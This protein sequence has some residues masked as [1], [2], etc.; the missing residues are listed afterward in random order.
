M[1]SVKTMVHHSWPRVKFLTP[2]H[3]C[4]N[5]QMSGV[6][7]SGPRTLG[8]C[9]GGTTPK[10]SVPGTQRYAQGFVSCVNLASPP[11]SGQFRADQSEAA[12][13]ARLR[14]Q[15]PDIRQS[16]DQNADG[17]EAGAPGARDR[18][19]GGGGAEHGGTGVGI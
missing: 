2:P 5:L 7:L 3:L 6:F 13:S 17:S 9:T 15:A 16:E 1:E 12:F 19:P 18:A 8:P 11:E 4:E 10:W 14:T